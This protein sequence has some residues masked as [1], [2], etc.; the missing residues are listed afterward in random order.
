VP[1][2]GDIRLKGIAIG[3]AIVAAGI[4][5]SLV[6]SLLFFEKQDAVVRPPIS[7]PVRLTDPLRERDAYLREK[8]AQLHSSEPGKIPIEEAMR[9]LAR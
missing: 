7:G 1:E 2:A 6:V 9:R 4:A 8:D 3:A 5:F